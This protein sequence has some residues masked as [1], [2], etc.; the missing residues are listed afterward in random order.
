MN[1]LKDKV[2]FHMHVMWYESQMINE[3]LDSLYLALNN[4][5]LNVDIKICL[6][7][8]T[9]IE[10]PIK[11]NADDM[12]NEFINHFVLKNAE[13][14]HKT[15]DDDFYNI[16][17]WRR[18]IYN[19]EYKYIIWGESD[20]LIPEDYFYILENINIFE[21]H[22]LSLSSRKMWDDSWKIVEHVS[23]Q[24]LSK[25]HEELGILSCGGYIDYQ[26][27]CKFN[28]EI[29]KINI[30]KLPMNKIDGSMLALSPNLPS[31]F[32]SPN[33]HFVG[34]DT[35]AEI[36][37]KKHNIPQYH[38]STR[39]KGHNYNHHLKRTN[40]PNTRNDEIFKKYS[41]Q[42]KQAMYQFLNNLTI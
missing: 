35:C 6:N 29:D 28:L 14:I 11:G 22:I 17:D 20:T 23:L 24:N 9:Y 16:G 40:T 13:I 18:E 12:F 4:T 41:S 1:I 42:S 3:T 31:P 34:E 26:Q 2:L 15:N 7:S 37:F 21:P 38:I 33:Q 10:Q 27:L 25:S 8:Q 5:T 19:S 32:I 30:I 36:F 39:I